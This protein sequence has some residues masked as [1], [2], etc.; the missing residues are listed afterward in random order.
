MFASIS[1]RTTFTDKNTN[2]VFDIL[3][4]G[5]VIVKTSVRTA[6]KKSCC[7]CDC[8]TYV[9]FE[10]K[11]HSHGP[12]ETEREK[13]DCWD[14]IHS[15]CMDTTIR[16]VSG[17]STCRILYWLAIRENFS[18]FYRPQTMLRKGNVFT[19]VCHSVH[20]GEVDTPP[21]GHPLPPGIH[22]FPFETA[23]AADDTHP[24]GMH[25]SVQCKFA[26]DFTIRLILEEH[27]VAFPIA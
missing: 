19:P 13:W 2:I 18:F 10:K 1:E 16:G 4:V 6:A 5:F 22:P 12:T 11:A 17:I 27:K 26:S 24:T 20:R 25:S 3:P 8:V 7:V 23:T 21:G 14:K 15:H 9:H